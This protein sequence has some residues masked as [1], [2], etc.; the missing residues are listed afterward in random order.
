MTLNDNQLMRYSRN[1]LL[2]DI[3]ILGQEKLLSSSAMV[4]GLG[5]LG[6]PVASY[7]AASGVGRLVISDFDSVHISNLQRQ[8]IHSTEDLGRKKVKSAGK[9]T[10]AGATP[11]KKVGYDTYQKSLQNKVRKDIKC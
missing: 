4:I 2:S 10:S 6:S 8:I 9:K 3:D 1:I 7:L 11:K 5:G